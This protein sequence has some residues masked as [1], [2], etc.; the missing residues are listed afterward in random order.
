V[1]IV[2]RSEKTVGNWLGFLGAYRLSSIRLVNAK[3]AFGCANYVIRPDYRKGTT[4]LQLLSVFR[5]MSRHAVGGVWNQS[6]TSTIYKVL[7][8]EVLPLHSPAFAVFPDGTERMA[9]TTFASP[10]RIGVWSVRKA[11]RTRSASRDWEIRPGGR[12]KRTPRELG[13]H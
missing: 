2:S 4:A 8:G 6:A 9:K 10:I 5:N 3:K 11:W 12:V 13:Q 7:R 1:V